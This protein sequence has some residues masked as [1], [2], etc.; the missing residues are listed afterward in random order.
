MLFVPLL[1]AFFSRGGQLVAAQEFT[2]VVQV[3]DRESYH[4]DNQNWAVTSS[5][6]GLMYF[7][8]GSG[9]LSFDGYRWKLD[10]IPGSKLVRSAFAD[11]DR[12]YV[13]S[14]EQFGYFRC[15]DTGLMEYHS[16]SDS[17]SGYQMQNDEIWRIIK[18]GDRI[19]FQSFTSFFVYDGTSVTAHRMPTVCLFFIPYGDAIYTSTDDYGLVTVNVDTG[20][21]DPVA[22]VPFSGKLVSMLPRPDGRALAVTYSDGLYLFDGVRFTRFETEVDGLLPSWQ[23]NNAIVT[24]SGDII[25]GTK[26]RGAVCIS[27]SGEFKWCVNNS[28][29]LGCNTVLGM[30]LDIE[31]NLWLALDGGVAIIRVDPSLTYIRSISPSVGSIYTLF[32]KSPNLYM[33]TGQGLYVGELDDDFKNLSDVRPVKEVLGNVWHIDS[34]GG[35]IFCGTNYETFDIS[36]D[37]VSVLSS[38][39]GGSCMDD[40]MINGKD[41]L[42]QGTYTHLCIYTRQDGKWRFSHSLSD[43]VQPVSSIEV[44]YSGTIWAAHLHKGLYSICLTE[45]LK[46][47]D[48]VTFYPSLDGRTEGQIKVYSVNNRV[49]FLDGKTGFYTYD[50][51][52]DKIVPYDELNEALADYSI[53]CTICPF[54]GNMYW[55]VSSAQAVL[56]RFKGNDAIVEDCVSYDVFG[57]RILDENQ[58]MTPVSDDDCLIALGNSLALYSRVDSISRPQGRPHFSVARVCMTDMESHHDSLLPLVPAELPKVPYDY[59]NIS[60]DFH[61]PYFSNE[62][63]PHFMFRIDGQDWSAPSHEPSVSYAY[64]KRGRHVV[65]AGVCSPSGELLSETRYEFKVVT[66]FYMSVAAIVLYAVVVLGSVF[67]GMILFLRAKEARRIEEENAELESQV[68]LKSKELAASTMNVIQKNELLIKIRKELDAG[69]TDKA[70]SI[71]D[72]S[73]TS[74][75]EWKMFETNF[76]NLHEHFFRKLRERY[77][78]LTDNDLRFCAYL[79]LNLSSKDMASLMNISLKGVEAAR[80]R[81]RKKIG[82]PSTQSLTTFMIELK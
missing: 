7:G 69:R 81:I 74:D 76:D 59:R 32:Y 14:H 67:M 25:I 31:G 51:L 55:F 75:Q 73:L 16:I 45:D 44:D 5:D 21:L 62:D 39:V 58:T 79:R 52:N 53:S 70:I 26:L 6:A 2:P 30:D 37:N 34:Y 28:N 65:E 10:R 41:V 50:Y 63:R 43:F 27:S 15:K 42:V 54:Y 49:V 56:V 1:L 12:V 78:A 20:G 35:Q 71:I 61:C 4:A 11:G 3:Y 66:P 48:T 68:K 57:S 19:I 33:G 38:I 29:V 64:L 82:L 9:M 36:D 80:A 8:N 17:L 23:P 24:S 40:G 72:G 18:H 22:G 60:F 47:I 77:P 13:G 46:E